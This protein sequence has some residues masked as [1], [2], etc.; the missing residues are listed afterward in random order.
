MADTAKN[1]PRITA[2]EYFKLTADREDRTELLDGEIVAMAS[3]SIRH[4]DI[5]S[6][7]ITELRQFVKRNGGKCRPFA[8]P[9]YVRL[10]DLNVLVPDVFV[11]CDPERFG[12]QYH[13]GAPDF[14]VEI[15]STNRSD[16]FSRKL[17][18]YRRSGVREYWIIDPRK[19]N[20]LVYFFEAE[21]SP[22]IY[23]FHTPIPVH[24]WNGQLSITIAD[25]E[26]L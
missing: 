5:A 26:M 2:E 23:G 13:S 25:L 6:G 15:V 11:S 3:P 24:I 12:E 14:V 16:D 4:Q 8:A 18:L 9:T 19:E 7:L 10:D 17:W 1:V 21:D 20:V 22:E